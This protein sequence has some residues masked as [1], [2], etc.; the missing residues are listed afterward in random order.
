MEE[1]VTQPEPLVAPI[2][3]K[4]V[5]K[6]GR[7]K[8]KHPGG[9]PTVMTE[10]T[11]R[12]LEEVFALGGTDQE[13]CMWADISHQTL[14][15]YQKLNPK[16][17]ERKEALKET[18]ILRARRTLVGGLEKDPDLS[19]KY[20]ERKRKDE[21]STKQTIEHGADKE[22]IS[23]LTEFFRSIAKKKDDK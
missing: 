12:K 10:E 2:E 9:R 17:V 19:L 1:T 14:Y 21:F 4:V 16:F 18:P 15:D 3:T 11:I 13:A 20:L 23:E 5:N 6:G 7:P 22:S 8:K